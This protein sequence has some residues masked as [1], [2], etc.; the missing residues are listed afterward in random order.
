MCLLVN[1][2]RM[3]LFSYNF[4]CDSIGS[5]ITSHVGFLSRIQFELNSNLMRKDKLVASP[6]LPAPQKENTTNTTINFAICSS[7]I[8]KRNHGGVF[9]RGHHRESSHGFPCNSAGFV[10][11]RKG[12]ECVFKAWRRHETQT[13]Q[14]GLDVASP[15][16]SRHPF[17]SYN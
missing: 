17:L 3:S 8:P 4:N 16:T 2:S 1:L 12:R 7:D 15:P 13:P 11:P 10:L 9:F 14:V 5:P 6:Y